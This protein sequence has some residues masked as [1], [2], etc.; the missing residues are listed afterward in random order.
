MSAGTSLRKC[1]FLCKDCFCITCGLWA[2][3]L[4]SQ[5]K[6]SRQVCRQCILRFQWKDKGQTYFGKKF[7]D[8]F[9]FAISLICCFL[10]KG[11]GQGCQNCILNVRGKNLGMTL[12]GKFMFFLSF[13]SKEPKNL[14]SL[15]TT[16]QKCC[17]KCFQPVQRKSLTKII[18][19]N[20]S[21]FHY[22]PIFTRNF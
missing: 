12:F 9:F 19:Q 10:A 11:L 18:F 14:G 15:S 7:L 17:K 3:T 21:L 5:A 20:S 2:K 6:F 13:S 8:F 22:F 16:M 1:F 4:T